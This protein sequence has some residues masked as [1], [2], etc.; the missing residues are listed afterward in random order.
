MLKEDIR[1]QC[2][3]LTTHMLYSAFY[4]IVFRLQLL[5]RNDNRRVKNLFW[6][7][8][9]L[10]CHIRYANYWFSCH[11]KRYLL[12]M[13]SLFYFLLFIAIKP[14]VIASIWV[15]FYF[16]INEIYKMKLALSY[17]SEN[18]YLSTSVLLDKIKG[19]VAVHI[20]K[21]ST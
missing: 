6:Q 8:W 3:I 14:H 13:N 11:M 16:S 21:F 5:S 1:C 19:K 12:D 4:D 18:M 2:L 7:T 10:L 15:N 9:S 17:V 20:N